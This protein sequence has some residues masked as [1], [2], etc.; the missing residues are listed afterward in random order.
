MT[1][2]ARTQ[3]RGTDLHGAAFFEVGSKEAGSLHVHAHGAEDNS[4]VILV[5]VYGGLSVLHERGLATDLCRHFVVRQTCSGEEGD[6]LSSRHGVHGVNGGNTCLD[7]CLRVVAAGRV[8]R[9]A[10]NIQEVLREHGWCSVDLAPGAV[11]GAS[12]HLLCDGHLKHIA[13]EFAQCLGHINTRRAWREGG[14]S[15]HSDKGSKDRRKKSR[16]ERKKA[17]D[18]AFCRIQK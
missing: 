6:L 4:K 9:S 8:D 1:A 18:E 10:S 13:A 14:G 12:E 11:E 15:E 5:R 7:H 2:G 17:L 16:N 3:G